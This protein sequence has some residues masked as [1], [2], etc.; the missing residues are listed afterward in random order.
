MRAQAGEGSVGKGEREEGKGEMG[1]TSKCVCPGKAM[2]LEREQSSRCASLLLEDASKA[3]G[4]HPSSG[5]VAPSCSTKGLTRCPWPV[6]SYILLLFPPKGFFCK[7]EK[8]FDSWCSLVQKVK[9]CVFLCLKSRSYSV[10]SLFRTA[11]RSDMNL[12]W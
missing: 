4:P 3:S 1:W 9:T 5:P 8:D 11:S 6:L 10:G 12:A 7:E 2:T